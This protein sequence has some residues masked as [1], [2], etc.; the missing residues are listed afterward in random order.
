MRKGREILYKRERKTG[1]LNLRVSESE[2]KQINQISYEDDETV[3]Q[4]IR[5]AI[6]AYINDREKRKE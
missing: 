4:V 1:R 5:K 6:K 3:A 2:M